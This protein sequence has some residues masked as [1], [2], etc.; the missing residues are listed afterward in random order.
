VSWL[1]TKSGAA[2]LSVATSASLLGL[3]LAVGLVTGSISVLSEALHSG[4]DLLAAIIALVAVHAADRPADT[5]HPY[6]HGKIEHVSALVEAVLIFLAA[7]YIVAE[8]YHRLF[9]AHPVDRLGTAIAVMAV[10]A[11]A[12][13]FLS[14]HLFRVA[15]ET[16]SP[17]LLA[18]AHQV[19]ADVYSSAGVMG[20]LLLIRATGQPLFDPIIAILVA[21]LIVRAAWDLTQEAGGGLLDTRLPADEIQRLQR[22]LDSDPRIIGYHHVRARRAGPHRHVDLHL[23]VDPEMSLRAAHRLA[24]E[25]ED[26]IRA[27]LANVT[28]VT[29]VEPATEEELAVSESEPGIW[30]GR[31][32]GR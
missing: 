1:R 4:T 31:P 14:R 24:E 22:V 10:S 26:R 20:G 13:W 23:L 5:R 2:W 27:E 19:G 6:G 8:A 15:H 21:A 7:G 9:V 3:K 16:D 17:A 25:I 18:D 32:V 28:I 30:K 11:V 12:S 29:H